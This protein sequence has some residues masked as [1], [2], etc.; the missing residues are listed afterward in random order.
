MR[1]CRCVALALSVEVVVGPQAERVGPKANE[2][3]E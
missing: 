1:I 2:T 3:S